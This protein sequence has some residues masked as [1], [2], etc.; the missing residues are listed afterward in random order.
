MKGGRRGMETPST[1][2]IYTF[3]VFRKVRGTSCVS[4]FLSRRT[5]VTLSIFWYTWGHHE[6][7]KIWFTQAPTSVVSLTILRFS[8]ISLLHGPRP[9]SSTVLF[10]DWVKGGTVDALCVSRVSFSSFLAKVVRIWVSW[11]FVIYNIRGVKCWSPLSLDDL[12]CLHLT[13]R[14][15]PWPSSSTV[16]VTS[17]TTPSPLPLPTSLIRTL[18]ECPS[19]NRRRKFATIRDRSTVGNKTISK[20]LRLVIETPPL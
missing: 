3:L 14:R 16:D 4:Y 17:R 15:P 2:L 13:F 8:I 5:P 6:V 11:L 7:C 10:I 18:L 12:E 20:I 1:T 9:I 19:C